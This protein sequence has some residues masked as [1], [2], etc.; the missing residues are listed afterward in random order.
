MAKNVD[1]FI[2]IDGFSH[3]NHRYQWFFQWF[4]SLNHCHWMNGF[5]ASPL[6]SMVFQWFWRKRSNRS[7]TCSYWYPKIYPILSWNFIDH[8]RQIHR[9][10]IQF[11][12]FYNVD[13]KIVLQTQELF[14]LWLL[15][16]QHLKGFHT[17]HCHWMNGWKATID[18]NGFLSGNHWY[19]CFFN[20]FVVRQPLDPMVFQWFPMVANHWSNDGMVTIHRYGLHWSHLYI[21]WRSMIFSGKIWFPKKFY[22]CLNNVHCWAVTNRKVYSQA[23]KP[24]LGGGE[25]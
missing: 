9:T 5:S 19:Q 4:S 12:T 10:R 17:H 8:G 1:R 23:S 16:L 22:I 21:W 13:G 3:F 11:Q 18:I 2:V 24:N 14:A 25:D 6:T 20:G 15:P 7:K